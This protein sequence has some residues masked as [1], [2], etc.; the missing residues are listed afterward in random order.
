MTDTDTTLMI[1]A[2]IVLAIY[3]AWLWY[4]LKNAI[5]YEDS[6]ENQNKD[7]QAHETTSG[8]EIPSSE[9]KTQQEARK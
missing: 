1:G 8:E 9:T 4:E 3:S 6:T 5:P 2:I 7:A